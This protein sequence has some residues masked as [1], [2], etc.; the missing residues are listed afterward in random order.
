MTKS[1]T[2]ARE[3]DESAATNEDIAADLADYLRENPGVCADLSTTA[4]HHPW[5]RYHDGEFQMFEYAGYG[6]VEVQTVSRESLVSLMALNPVDLRPCS[7]ANRGISSD[8][9]W[10]QVEYGEDV[11]VL[12]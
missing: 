4:G 6:T 7:E 3:Q 5:V 11:E 1:D 12:A 10:E 8:N 2:Q 9:I